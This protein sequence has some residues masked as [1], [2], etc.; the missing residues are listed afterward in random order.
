VG[1]ENYLLTRVDYNISAR[2]SLFVR[3]IRDDANIVYPFL[4][5]P[6]R[7]NGRKWGPQLT[8]S[9]P[10][11]TGTFF[12]QHSQ[13]AALQFHADVRIGRGA[14]S[15]PEPR[16]DLLPDLRPE[17]R[18]NITGLSSIGPSIYAPLGEAQNKFRFR[19]T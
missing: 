18:V 7:R 16:A 2:D 4:G 14:T 3:Y 8:T 5:S 17:R 10:L 9:R 6:C 15:R 1:N 11:N 13:P 12:I 19:T